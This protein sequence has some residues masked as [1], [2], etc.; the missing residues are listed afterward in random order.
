MG[1]WK[2]ARSSKTCAL[3]GRTLP[4]DAPVVTAL[5]GVD[6]EVSDD[7]VRGTGMVRKDFLADA[8]AAELEKALE[9]AYCT[10]RTRTP[11]EDGAKAHR[12]DLGLARELLERLVKEDDPAKGAVVLTLALLL[13]RKRQL[14]LVG[15]RQSGEVLEDR[16]TVLTLRWPKTEE[17][18]EVSAAPIAEAE[19]AQIQDELGRLFDF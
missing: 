10:W 19:E 6:E 11:P 15:E 1:T 14:T 3:T 17:T 13:V 12:L 16:S 18:F 4:P 8:P 9:G 2:V 7:K 5:F